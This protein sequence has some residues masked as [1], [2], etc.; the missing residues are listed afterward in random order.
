[1][2]IEQIDEDNSASRSIVF[3]GAN[4]ELSLGLSFNPTDKL[5]FEAMCG[6]DPVNNS[7]SVF[8]TGNGLFTF[9]NILVSLRF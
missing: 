4:T 7:I 8:H 3:T 9:G 2:T 6:I 5:S 1:M